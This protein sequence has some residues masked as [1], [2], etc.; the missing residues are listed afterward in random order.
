M[1]L[2]W[3]DE[4]F[5]KHVIALH[6]QNLLGF[7]LFLIMLAKNK[8][9]IASHQ[10]QNSWKEQHSK[11]LRV[12]RILSGKN[13]V[14]FST[15]SASSRYQSSAVNCA[16][17]SR[18]HISSPVLTPHRSTPFPWEMTCSLFFMTR[19]VDHGHEDAIYLQKHLLHGKAL[20]HLQCNCA[21]PSTDH[22]GADICNHVF[23]VHLKQHVDKLRATRLQNFCHMN[24]NQT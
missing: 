17:A 10:L 3:Q 15:M 20:P 19:S 13:L 21:V 11:K 2:H 5:N 23:S 6:I 4:S 24:C 18:G 9:A 7:I 12:L 14:L 22:P 16:K 1:T 8:R